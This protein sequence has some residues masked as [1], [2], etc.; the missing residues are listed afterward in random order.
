M[1]LRV[2]LPP[3]SLLIFGTSSMR[4]APQ[5]TSP[6]KWVAAIFSGIC[7]RRVRPRVDFLPHYL[8]C[9]FAAIFVD[10]GRRTCY[11][12]CEEIQDGPV[13]EEKCGWPGP[14]FGA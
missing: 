2:C 12:L 11:A 7:S 10:S 3:A 9:R 5:T 4:C 14:G 13:A 6:P 8:N 1:R